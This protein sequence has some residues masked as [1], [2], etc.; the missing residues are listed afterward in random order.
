MTSLTFFKHF[1]T[2]FPPFTP[3]MPHYS[4]L[5]PKPHRFVCK[6]SPTHTSLIVSLYLYLPSYPNTLKQIAL[7]SNAFKDPSASFKA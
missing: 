6:L 4:P 5:F 1:S 2:P 7:V 3:I